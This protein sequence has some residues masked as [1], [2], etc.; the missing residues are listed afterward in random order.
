V[1]GSDR[2]NGGFPATWHTMNDNVK[3]INKETL[4]AVGQTML[5]VIW[6]EQ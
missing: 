3:N 6:T 1:I 5:E 2:E 4:K